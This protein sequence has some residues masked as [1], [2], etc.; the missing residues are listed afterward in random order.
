[1]PVCTEC[2]VDRPDHDFYERRGRCDT[3]CKPCK[4][5]YAAR[6]RKENHAKCVAYDRARIAAGTHN[7]GRR[8]AGE[9]ERFR[10]PRC[11][12]PGTTAGPCHACDHT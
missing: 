9:A 8:R 12:R 4:R 6:Y 3:R 5:A 11:D 2:G 1:M 10:C 7:A